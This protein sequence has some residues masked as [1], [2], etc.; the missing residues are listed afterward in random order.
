MHLIVIYPYFDCTKMF[1]VLVAV[2]VFLVCLIGTI[3]N[4]NFLLYKMTFPFVCLLFA[5]KHTHTHPHIHTHT[6]DLSDTFE[7]GRE[8]DQIRRGERYFCI[9]AFCKTISQSACKH[10][11]FIDH[12]ALPLIFINH[13]ESERNWKKLLLTRIEEHSN[14]VLPCYKWAQNGETCDR[15]HCA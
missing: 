4:N 15:V 2:A 13:W 11:S 6:H 12:Y 8:I 5:V 10:Y 1:F 14:F 3:S 7:S 9:V